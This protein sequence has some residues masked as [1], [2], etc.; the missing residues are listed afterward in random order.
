MLENIK[1]GDDGSAPDPDKASDRGADTPVPGV[2]N[3]VVRLKTLVRY[4]QDK[5]G[6]NGALKA[7]VQP[8]LEHKYVSPSVLE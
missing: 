3:I 2:G 7:A 1:C 5:R 6:D 4:D 8:S